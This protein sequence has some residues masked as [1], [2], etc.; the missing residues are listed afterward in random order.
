[1]N[2]W[3][4][5][6]YLFVSI[7]LVSIIFAMM[8]GLTREIIS[9]IALIGGFILAAIYYKTPAG[10]FAS[11]TRNDSIAHL[12]GF[13]IIFISCILIG[14]IISYLV[15]RFIKAASLKWID[16]LLGGVFGLIRGWIICSIMVLAL[17]AFPVSEDL[18]ARSA[19]ATYMMAGARIVATVI[20]KGLKDQFDEQYKKVLQTWNK[21]R[22]AA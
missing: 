21:H 7:I 2:Q 9:L 11:Y 1:M 13:M 8:K 22:S 16:R 12:L 17:I 10:H 4:F 20:P 6:D 19:L 15:N 18:V 14:A 3:I 5:L